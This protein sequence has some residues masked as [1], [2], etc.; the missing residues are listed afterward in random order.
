MDGPLLNSVPEAAAQLRVSRACLYEL[1]G[2]GAL[3]SVHVGR[4]RLIPQSALHEFVA[5]READEAES[6]VP[7]G[8]AA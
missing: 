2:S 5:Q 8:G 6:R 1:I 3:R 7:R 4:R